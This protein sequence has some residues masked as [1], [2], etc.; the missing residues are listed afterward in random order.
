[1]KAE[2]KEI[3]IGYKRRWQML[4]W[5]EVFL[6]A[7]GPAVFVY[8]LTTGYEWPLIAFLVGFL[9]AAA[10]IRPWKLDLQYVSSHIDLELETAEYSTGLLLIPSEGLSGLA[11]LQQQKVEERLNNDIKSIKPQHN[12]IGTGSV[13]GIFIALGFLIYQFGPW[14]YFNSGRQPAGQEE[15][16]TFR[17]ADSVDNTI[18][19]P[20]LENQQV[21]IIY[22]AYTGLG[23]RTTTKM[24]IEAVEGSRIAWQI[25][26]DGEVE[27]AQMESMGARYD[28]EFNGE[29][30]RRRSVL[31]NSG[32]Y[33]FRFKDTLGGS[34]VS[35]LYSIEVT[36]DRSPVIEIPNLEQFTS[37]DFDEDKRLAFETRIT[38]DFG[39][40]EAYIIATVSKG[41]GESVKFREEQLHFAENVQRGSK[42][43]LLTKRINLDDLKMEPGDE[44]YFY[45]EATDLK[46]PQANKARS[47]TYFGVI[48]DTVS[49]GV[50]VEGNLGVDL[51]P[52]YFRSQRQLIIDTEKLIGNRN[53]LSTKEFNAT[54]N[55]LGFDQKALRLKY[56]QFMGDEAEGGLAAGSNEIMPG[57]EDHDNKDPLAE[58]IHDHDGSNEHNLVEQ[59]DYGEAKAGEGEKDP[60]EEYLHNHSDPEESTLF[61]D[62]L[63]S[64]LR[65]ALD[66]MWD[67]E[68]HLRLNEPE[69][70]LPFQY[71]ALGLIQ[72]IKNSARIYVHRIGFD[73]PP[74]KEE[75]RLT[76][77]IEEV[78]NYQKRE[79]LKKPE[80]YAAIRG[81]IKR[82]EQVIAGGE[83]IG[84]RDRKLF[85]QAGIELAEIAVEEPGKHLQTLQQL[86]W[87]TE[88]RQVDRQV[89]KDVQRGLLMALPAPEPEPGKGKDYRGKINEL[90]LKELELNDR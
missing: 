73:P 54:S 38:D 40:G 4:L 1:M 51:M 39:V 70:S 86:K 22:P 26:F 56:G 87:L 55:N 79:E 33:N 17:S 84:A 64:K 58:Y 61:A 42:D 60:L 82:L 44:L 67:A 83:N 59:H 48:K 68:L 28:M 14:T 63:K 27:N 29:A 15:M 30:F 47:E 18:Q 23:S 13:A 90:L 52:D 75:V 20:V 37:F 50:G 77:K 69:K 36:K 76:G 6:Y 46:Q 16:V 19:P 88:E 81:A 3:L 57:D 74:I 89:L 11:R 41:S 12:L 2:G 71:K 62:S 34:Y 80:K 7:V 66:I 21:N 5:L 8:F 53:K 32:F 10:V 65:Q 85:E 72:E 9:F 25:E 78:S 43:Q 35:D 24:N 49:Y 31:R 45:I